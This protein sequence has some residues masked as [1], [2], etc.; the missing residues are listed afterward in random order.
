LFVVLL[1]LLFPLLAATKSKS[2]PERPRCG[3]CNSEGAVTGSKSKCACDVLQKFPAKVIKRLELLVT[4]YNRADIVYKAYAAYFER[5]DVNL[6]GFGKYFR[7]H[8]AH[9]LHQAKTVMDY[10]TLRGAFFYINTIDPEYACKYTAK[11]L[12][13]KDRVDAKIC[14]FQVNG[15]GSVDDIKTPGLLALQDAVVIERHILD[16]IYT[17]L[18]LPK[19]D[20]DPY[21]E[22]FLEKLLTTER[23]K[24][25][26]S[27][28]KRL[29]LETAD[30]YPLGEYE[31]DHELQM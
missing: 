28:S 4:I 23:V 17:G 27:L 3:Y 29:S 14:N 19:Q 16:Q 7:G 24:A 8:S 15:E 25:I 13:S 21:T 2:D 22:H 12:K 11:N 1:P 26:K 6:P 10:L 31:M 9:M 20:T 30:A 5:A 18:K